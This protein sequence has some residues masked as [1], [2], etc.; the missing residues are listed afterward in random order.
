MSLSTYLSEILMPAWACPPYAG[1]PPYCA[2]PWPLFFLVINSVAGEP[3]ML[4][5][6]CAPVAGLAISLS[7]SFSLSLSLSLFPTLANWQDQHEGGIVYNMGS[8]LHSLLRGHLI[9]G[10]RLSPG[11][12]WLVRSCSCCFHDQTSTSCGSQCRLANLMSKS[13]MDKC[14]ELCWSI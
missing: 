3:L 12:V 10:T 9:F 7:L 8:R 4:A 11:V 5:W 14:V 1:C 2:H 13:V 6:V